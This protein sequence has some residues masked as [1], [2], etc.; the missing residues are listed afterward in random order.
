MPGAEGFP[1]KRGDGMLTSGPDCEDARR[2][3]QAAGCRSVNNML[4]RTVGWGPHPQSES[5]YVLSPME[6]GSIANT[7][8]QKKRDA[9]VESAGVLRGAVSHL[10]WQKQLLEW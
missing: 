5:S 3:A 9:G 1:T 4:N 2:P 6:A 7:G 8:A 10:W